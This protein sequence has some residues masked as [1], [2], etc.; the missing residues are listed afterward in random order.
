MKPTLE[1]D[2]YLLIKL[3][4][5]TEEQLTELFNKY[6]IKYQGQTWGLTTEE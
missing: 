1:M 6:N 5:M 4:T 2:T 3:H